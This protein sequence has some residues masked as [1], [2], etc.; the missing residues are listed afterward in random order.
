MIANNL[1]DLPLHS[2]IIYGMKDIDIRWVKNTKTKDSSLK[3][4]EREQW[5]EYSE[6]TATIELLGIRLK[7][8]E[9]KVTFIF[10]NKQETYNEWDL[11]S[12]KANTKNISRHISVQVNMIYN[13]TNKDYDMYINFPCGKYNSPLL[14]S[15]EFDVFHCA[16]KQI[17]SDLNNLLTVNNFTK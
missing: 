1:L 5:N 2:A 8:P 12:G 17:K 11:Q 7:F 13:E 4:V 9:A 14:N 6:N 15:R 10:P 3:L 16:V